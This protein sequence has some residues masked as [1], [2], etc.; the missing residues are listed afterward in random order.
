MNK[1]WV[2]KFAVLV[3]CLL[4]VLFL[5]N[6][7][8]NLYKPIELSRVDTFLPMLLFKH[9]FSVFLSG[10]WTNLFQA[11]FFNGFSNALF[12]SNLQLPQAFFALPFF[13]LTKNIIVSF[14][15]TAIGAIA[16]SFFS[17]YL[18]TFFFTR[19][20]LP[21]ILSGVIFV[22]NPFIFSRFP[23]HMDIYTLAFIP[24]I[25]LCFEKF[26]KDKKPKFLF[27]ISILL[28]LQLLAGLYYF[29]YLSVILP[30]Y[31]FVRFRQ[32]NTKLATILKK[33]AILGLIMLIGAGL[34][35]GIKY[36][37]VHQDSLINRD[38]AEAPFYSAWISD[39]LFASPQ[40]LIYGSLRDKVFDRFPHLVL[41]ASTNEERNLFWGIIPFCLFLLSFKLHKTNR[42]VWV[43]SVCL[44][45]LSLLFA[46]G[47]RINITDQFSIP[48]PYQII[49][50]LDPMLSLTRAISRFAVFGF[51]FLSLICAITFSDILIRFKGKA[52]LLGIIIVAAVILEY[53]NKPWQFTEITTST[54]QFY[55][56]LNRQDQVKVL[57]DLPIGNIFSDISTLAKDKY[58]DSTYMFWAAGL[59]NKKIINGNSGYIPPAYISLS[60]SL[61]INFPTK[62][63]LLD[64]K[65]RGV[66]GI[67]LHKDN[68][69]DP[70]E[71]ERE[72]SKLISLGI[73]PGFENTNLAFFDISLLKAP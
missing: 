63:K 69:K 73:N 48:G 38:S 32:T 58:I 46:A 12:F 65:K 50:F 47:P 56:T 26:L 18:L 72:R 39:L 54:R 34:P 43:L 5:H 31:G 70:L 40:N 16:I 4:T 61:S 42:P 68:Y 10:N 41:Y 53:W 28:I 24:I 20:V 6:F 17:M 7:V 14:N 9:Y 51:F 21:S 52:G 3:S 67:I 13:I 71:Y 35:L 37:S 49:S 33:E 15:L 55:E 36:Q 27:F 23:Q 44:L 57:L 19:Q 2:Q 59:H 64:L 45:A 1:I 22:F 29:A 11:P 60:E 62:N 30:I 25:F 8:I 66:D